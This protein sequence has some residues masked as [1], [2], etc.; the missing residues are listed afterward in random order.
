MKFRFTKVLSR[1]VILCTVAFSFAACT[2]DPTIGNIKVVDLATGD[3]I[4]NATVKIFIPPVFS[5]SGFTTCDQGFVTQKIMTTDNSG[6]VSFCLSLE[7]TLSIDVT[8]GT[9]TGTGVIACIREK[10]T[11]VTV[12]VQ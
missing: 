11:D 10:T 7:A 4:P 1:I 9:K 6:T 8:A 12:K 5:N 3:A 2:K